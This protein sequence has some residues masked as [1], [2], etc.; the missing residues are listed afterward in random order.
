MGGMMADKVSSLFRER[1]VLYVV[2]EGGRT[3][4]YNV[5]QEEWIALPPYGTQDSAMGWEEMR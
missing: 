5:E 1:G 3:Y 4:W 2:T